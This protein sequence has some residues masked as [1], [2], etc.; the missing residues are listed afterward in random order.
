LYKTG[1]L[2]NSRCQYCVG[3][4]FSCSLYVKPPVV[5]APKPA[6]KAARTR[7][8]KSSPEPAPPMSQSPERSKPL[9]FLGT[10]SSKLKGN[11]SGSK[12]EG[13][14]AS[15]PAA[16]SSSRTR[17]GG[18]QAFV[19]LPPPIQPPATSPPS[20]TRAGSSQ[21]SFV[22]APPFSPTVNFDRPRPVPVS[23]IRSTPS[24]QPPFYDSADAS[25]FA[26]GASSSSLASRPSMS[27]EPMDP[28]H[29]NYSY[30][31]ERL[32][33]QFQSS[34]ESLRIAQELAVATNELYTRDRAAQERR[35]QE[36]LAAVR[37]QYSSDASKGKQRRM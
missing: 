10:I 34:Q 18:P 20:R 1:Q 14:P 9:S 23:S 25:S 12:S 35:H 4:H 32:R 22:P 5:T 27:F 24:L 26:P 37:R 3:K 16:S 28:S 21:Q 29:P 7:R 19:S 6:A 15:P 30:E 17:S 8:Q 13:L 2:P 33:L 11:R 36:E 31:V